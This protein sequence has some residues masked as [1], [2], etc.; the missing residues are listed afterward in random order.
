[1]DV[2]VTDG[3]EGLITLN[4]NQC[5]S[6]IWPLWYAATS[7]NIRSFVSLEICH[8]LV[9]AINLPID[10]FTDFDKNV[11]SRREEPYE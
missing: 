6:H 3:G 9:N 7:E 1:L 8:F 2:P 5:L 11:V 4:S 10:K